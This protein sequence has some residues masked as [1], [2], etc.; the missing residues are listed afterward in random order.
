MRVWTAHPAV[1]PEMFILSL[2]LPRN[3]QGILMMF[4]NQLEYALKIVG[5][6]QRQNEH[7]RFRRQMSRP[8]LHELK[9][10][11]KHKNMGF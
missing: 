2:N 4:R 8:Y 10:D 9:I 6:I 3:F 1:E 7:F 11:K 5:E